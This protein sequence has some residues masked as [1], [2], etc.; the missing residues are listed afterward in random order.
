MTALYNTVYN[1]NV[2][3]VKLCLELGC[4]V[5]ACTNRGETALYITCFTGK[6]AV[7]DLLL[8]A[9]KLPDM[10]NAADHTG[11]AWRRRRPS[12]QTPG[13]TSSRKLKNKDTIC[14]EA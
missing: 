9:G 8:E 5:D 4:S 1:G 12:G 13:R 7:V 10:L 14:P 3:G 11:A 2:E 6:V